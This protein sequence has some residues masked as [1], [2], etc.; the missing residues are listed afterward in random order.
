MSLFE[1]EEAQ[2]DDLSPSVSSTDSLP[3]AKKQ[4]VML[5]RLFKKHAPDNT[6]VSHT[7]ISPEQILQTELTNYLR[8]LKPDM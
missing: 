4:K 3:P 6:D 8:Q 2:Q 1:V 7:D 5:V